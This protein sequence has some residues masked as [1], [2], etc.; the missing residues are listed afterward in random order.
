MGILALRMKELVQ[1]TDRQAMLEM[2]IQTLESR[3]TKLE[4]GIL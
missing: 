3:Q 1:L 4:Y 2:D